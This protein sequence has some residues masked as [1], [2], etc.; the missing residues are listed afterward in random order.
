[1]GGQPVIV[2]NIQNVFLCSISPPENKKAAIGLIQYH[3][4]ALLLF[5]VYKYP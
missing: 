5:Y 4:T 3:S 2:Q 1:M